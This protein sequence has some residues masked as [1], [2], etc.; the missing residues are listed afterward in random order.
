V[1]QGRHTQRDNSSYTLERAVNALSCS[2]LLRHVVTTRC[3]GGHDYGGR[4]RGGF[5][6][7]VGAE[8]RVAEGYVITEERTKELGGCRL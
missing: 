3:G 4:G 7:G 8:G 6:E 2:H 5:A 1:Q